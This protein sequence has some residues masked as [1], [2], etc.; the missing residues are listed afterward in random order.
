LS[1]WLRDYLYIPLG[2][3]RGGAFATSRNLML[4]MV[5]GGLWHGANWTFLIWGAMHGIALV[6]DRAWRG[7]ALFARI[8]EAPAVKAAYWFVTFH[9][10]CFAWLFFRAPSLDAVSAYLGGLVVDNGAA[11]TM[12]SDAP[13]LIACGALTQMVPANARA[14]LG[15]RLDARAPVV[16]GAFGFGILYLVLVMAPSSSAPFIYFQF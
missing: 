10:V 15:A 9:F 14:I 11:I 1:N 8:G 7:G 6:A 4:T 12:P 3:N 2:G 13:V 5:L 16:Q